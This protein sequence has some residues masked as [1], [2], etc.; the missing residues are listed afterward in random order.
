MNR[1]FML[2]A[3]AL[4]AATGFAHGQVAGSTL[5]AK[6]VLEVREV[7]T[8]WSAVRQILGRAVVNEHGESI[9][10]VQD[11]IVAPDASVSHVIVGA[12]GFLGMRRHEVAI[13][14]SVLMIADDKLV[15]VGA[16]AG[17]IEAMSGVRVRALAF[18]VRQS[19]L[20]TGCALHASRPSWQCESRCSRSFKTTLRT[21]PRRLAQQ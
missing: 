19:V 5:V 4:V 11:I 9:G 6:A 10:R 15:L 13:P 8:G 2:C 20:V 1:R 16:A 3:L 14:V 21:T 17:A 7:A 12:G 18:T